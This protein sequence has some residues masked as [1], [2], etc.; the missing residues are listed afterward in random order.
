MTAVQYTDTE[1]LIKTWLA[2]TTVAP[3][4]ARSTGVYSIYLAMPKAAPVPAVV[5]TLIS[6]TTGN[7]DQPTM[8]SRI[9]FDCW[10]RTRNEASSISLTL[11]NELESLARTDGYFD[12]TTLL[13][14]ANVVGYRWLPD[15]ESDTARYIV[16]AL[17]TTV[18]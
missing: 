14:S 18:T 2:G 16:D 7:Y 5:L 15:P 4:V 3:L 12:G 9:Q 10:A 13:A 17:I 6:G 11:I 8:T 1:N